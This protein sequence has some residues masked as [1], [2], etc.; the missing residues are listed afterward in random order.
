MCLYSELKSNGLK[1]CPQLHPH[2]GI[3][4]FGTNCNYREYQSNLTAALGFYQKNESKTAG[5]S[6]H[7]L[8]THVCYTWSRTE[9]SLHFE[10]WTKPPY[11]RDRNKA[12]VSKIPPGST[13]KYVE[14]IIVSKTTK[15]TL[16]YLFIYLLCVQVKR[17]KKKVNKSLF[18]EKRLKYL[19]GNF[20]LS[21]GSPL[22]IMQI[23]PSSHL[24]LW[25]CNQE[26]NSSPPSVP[27]LCD[28]Q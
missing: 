23:A 15:I 6:D 7:S 10:L 9:M 8:F 18:L 3:C 24:P 25:Q 20:L 16:I 17:K 13:I 12:E 4:N 28:H 21:T 2:D 22:W 26:F 5:W 27:L 14:A 11:H 1:F 19:F